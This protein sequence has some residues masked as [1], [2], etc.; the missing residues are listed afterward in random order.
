MTDTARILPLLAR[1]SRR[2]EGDVSLAALAA[3]ARRSPFEVHRA[4]RRAVGETLKQY[5]LR[6]RIDRAAAEL[7]TGGRT[8]LEIALD[9]GFASHEVFTR[10][11]RRRFGMTPRAYRERGLEGASPQAA[12]THAAVVH[13]VAPCVGL[14]RIDSN[15][16]RNEMTVTV[17]RKDLTPQPA[18]VIRR[19]IKAADIPTTL[20][21]I[22]PR[23]YL[24]AQQHGIALAGPPFTRYLEVG[25]GLLTIEGGMAVA[26]AAKA[27]G[28]IEPTELAGGPAAVA[29]HEG[30]YDSLPET[31]A[32]IEQWIEGQG[33]KAGGAP[34]EVYLTDPGDH[35]DPKD[36]RT[37]VIWPL[38][39]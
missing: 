9:T 13:Q 12:A 30:G 22:L 2:L 24:H 10:A 25:P 23:V 3:L 29:I 35:P 19:R 21:E 4:F 7:L 14:Y 38:A 11:F 33:H 20:A 37:E 26:T 6:V 31:H 39:S 15:P 8:I 5:T 32:A 16:R 34:W 28:E 17:S 36:W 1:L 27:E 18:L